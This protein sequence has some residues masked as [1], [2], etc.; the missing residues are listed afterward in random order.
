MTICVDLGALA[1][2]VTEA[3]WPTFPHGT[4]P[5]YLFSRHRTLPGGKQ[6]ADARNGK[7]HRRLG[8]TNRKQAAGVA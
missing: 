1:D 3:V 7:S 8:G 5:D 6:E 4:S 2:R